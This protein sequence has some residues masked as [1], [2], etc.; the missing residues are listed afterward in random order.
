MREGRGEPGAGAGFTPPSPY[1]LRT[2]EL[3]KWRGE[4]RFAVVGPSFVLPL[5]GDPAPP[6][7]GVLPATN[8]WETKEARASCR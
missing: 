8:R 7:V 5:P 4:G 6:P 1:C 2:Q 3:S